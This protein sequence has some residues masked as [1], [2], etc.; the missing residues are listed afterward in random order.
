H[1]SYI[2]GEESQW[3]KYKE[4]LRTQ[5]KGKGSLILRYKKFMKMEDEELGKYLNMKRQKAVDAIILGDEDYI[6]E[7]KRKYLHAERNYGEIPQAKRIKNDLM[8]KK[9]K[10][11]VVK[12]FGINEK[13]FNQSVRG[14]EN[15]ARMVAIGLARESGGLSYRDIGRIFGGISYKSAAKYCERL[16]IRCAKEKELNKL[17]LNLKLTCSQVET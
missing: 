6:D 17:F 13:E 10:K 7:I 16:K 2:R 5:W 1:N 9:I 4:T 14:K 15:M 8:I 12:I 11:E 3:L